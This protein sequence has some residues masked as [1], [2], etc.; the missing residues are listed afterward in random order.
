MMLFVGVIC[1]ELLLIDFG[2]ELKAQ[3]A[4]KLHKSDF[5]PAGP[6]DK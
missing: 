5:V 2:G 3:A 1:S 6:I 4:S